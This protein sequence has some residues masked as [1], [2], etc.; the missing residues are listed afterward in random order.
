MT[1]RLTTTIL[2]QILRLAPMGA[3]EARFLKLASAGD[4][5]DFYVYYQ[6]CLEDFPDLDDEIEKAGRISFRM[7]RPAMDAVYMAGRPD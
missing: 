2:F 7:L 5:E 3:S 4:P 1:D 6:R